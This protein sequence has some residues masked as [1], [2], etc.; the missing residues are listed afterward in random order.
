ASTRAT[1]LLFSATKNCGAVG[2]F[3]IWQSSSG[4]VD[5]Q[6]LFP[7]QGDSHSQECCGNWTTDG[8]YFIFQA[9]R[10]GVTGIWAM[11]EDSHFSPTSISSPVQLTSGPIRFTSPLP[12]KD[13]KRIFVIGEQLRGELTRFD[14]KSQKFVRYLSG[15]SAEQLNFSRDGQWV[16]YVTYPEAVLWKSRIDGSHRQQL[17]VRPLQASVPRWSPNGQ[18]IA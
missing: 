5:L 4:G 16:T 17:T 6:R 8:K 14:L 13:G 15:I 9:T 11:R 3:A 1:L 12:S 18:Q 10:D 7:V 2:S